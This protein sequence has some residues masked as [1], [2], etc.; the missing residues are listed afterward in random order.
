MGGISPAAGRQRRGHHE[1]RLTYH[2]GLSQVTQAVAGLREMT[3]VRWDVSASDGGDARLSV[4]PSASYSVSGALNA[5]A[6]VHGI[7]V[8]AGLASD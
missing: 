3:D 6:H 8:E 1:F 4:V 2:G 5:M 7:A